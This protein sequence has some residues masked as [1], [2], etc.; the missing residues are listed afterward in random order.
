MVRIRRKKRLEYACVVIDLREFAAFRYKIEAIL[1]FHGGL[2]K[3]RWAATVLM[4]VLTV[5]VTS[6]AA[7]EVVIG[8]S[9]P[10]FS[11]KGSDGKDYT[12]AEYKGKF[13]VLEWY[14]RDCPFIHKHYDSG[15]MQKLQEAYGKKGVAWFE[16]LSSAPGSEGYLTPAETEANRAQSATKSIATLLDPDGAIGKQYGA[17]TTPHMFV[18]DPKGVLIYKGAIDDHNSADAADIPTSKNYVAAALDEAMAGKPVAISNTKPYG[19][20]VKYK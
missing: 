4:A 10:L 9:A 13:V 1:N 14:N 12:L 2:M 15:N 5:G 19:C 18:I 7:A 6:Y 8:K 3:N 20:G 16:V 17:K 11:G